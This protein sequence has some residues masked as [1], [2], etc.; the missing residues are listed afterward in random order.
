V[1][2]VCAQWCVCVCNVIS[3]FSTA[4]PESA[5][6][7]C[8]WCIDV[9]VC[10]CACEWVCEMSV[11]GGPCVHVCVCSCACVWVGVRGCKFR[12]MYVCL[13]SCVQEVYIGVQTCIHLH[14]QTC[15]RD[16]MHMCACVFIHARMYASRHTCTG[17]YTLLHP[18]THTRMSRHIRAHK[19][20]PIQTSHTPIHTRIHTPAHLCTTG[21]K[22]T[23]TQA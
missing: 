4:M 14:M 19:A 10:V 18:P 17:T 15:I 11:L 5:F 16:Y 7:L 13:L 8:L 22:Q 23:Q 3:I 21:T 6:V 12:Y 1:V 9:Q 20:P 2:C